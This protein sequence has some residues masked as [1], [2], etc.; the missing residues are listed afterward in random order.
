MRLCGKPTKDG[1][2]CQQR[3]GS[4]RPVCPFHKGDGA[5]AVIGARAAAARRVRFMPV[6]SANPDWSSVQAIRAWAE[7]RA[8]RVERGELDARAVPHELAKLAKATFDAEAQERLLDALLRLE[9]GGGA[10]AL[11][12]QFTNDPSKRKPLPGR[13]LTSLPKADG[14]G[15]A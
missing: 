2:R 12:A 13:V 5:M 6:G 11:L 1:G 8:G 9:H 7:E 4:S 15:A 10:V 14:D 3:L